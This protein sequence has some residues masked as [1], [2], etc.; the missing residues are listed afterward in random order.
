MSELLHP[1]SHQ[2]KVPSFE[3]ATAMSTP[4]PSDSGTALAEGGLPNQELLEKL[5]KAS[6]GDDS[7]DKEC[8]QRDVN[9]EG[10]DAL[11]PPLPQRQ[12]NNPMK[13]TIK[14][15]KKPTGAQDGTEG[16]QAQGETQ[17]TKGKF[18]F[19]YEC[20]TDKAPES[21]KR[22]PPLS[23]V[24]DRTPKRH[25][26]ASNPPYGTPT[27]LSHAIPGTRNVSPTPMQDHP[28]SQLTDAATLAHGGVLGGVPTKGSGNMAAESANPAGSEATS[29]PR[30]GQEASH[31]DSTFTLVD[32]NSMRTETMEVDAGHPSPVSRHTSPASWDDLMA[33]SPPRTPVS[34]QPRTTS[35]DATQREGA[36]AAAPLVQ[37]RPS[38]PG[39]AVRP[40]YDEASTENHITTNSKGLKRTAEPNGGWP[41]VH[42][43]STP[44]ENVAAQQVEAWGTI[45]GARLWVR[46]FKAKYEAN[47]LQTVDLTRDVIRNLVRIDSEVSLGV[48]FPLQMRAANAERFPLPYH[49]LVSGLSNAQVDYL[50]S[51]GVV[52]TQEATVFFRPFQ[53]PRPSF[54]ATVYGLTF[55]N[56]EDAPPVVA[57]IIKRR[58]GESKDIIAHVKEAL[59]LRGE[60]A[61]SEILESIVVKFIEVKRNPGSGGNFRGWNVYLQH[62][63]LGDGDHVRLIKLMRKCDFPTAT[64]GYGA[65]LR[66]RNILLCVGCKSIDHDTPN[67]PFPDIPGW[68]GPKPSMQPVPDSMN[69][70]DD[71]AAN[72]DDDPVHFRGRG[73]GRGGNRGRRYQQRRNGR[74]FWG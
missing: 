12:G 63:S 41:R 18:R 70:Y 46:T 32:Y 61:L 58:I 65:P 43:A 56:T 71:E 34:T 38:P 27:R 4:P 21:T 49:M 31:Y 51:L 30:A 53:D 33:D 37:G 35:R 50:S 69:A 14:L 3:I 2:E 22:P 16:L 72:F 6:L 57:D 40:L 7:R 66:G 42:L 47:S 28:T 8:S 13:L 74:G 15:N 25:T 73:R 11:F 60:A 67:C 36:L 5:K 20:R 19:T 23:P 45:D 55:C 1:T 26:S 9:M 54:V 29:T 64:S 39:A 10:Y 17:A 62:S 52:S 68:M 24:K 44:W 48:S 59:P